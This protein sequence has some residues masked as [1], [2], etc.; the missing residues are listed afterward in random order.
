MDEQRARR[1]AARFGLDPGQ[2]QL[3]PLA[4]HKERAVWRVGSHALKWVAKRKQARKIAAAARYLH[5]RGA[6]VLPPVADPLQTEKGYFLLF[7]WVDG[8]QP[9][10]TEPGMVE[11]ITRLLSEFHRASEG[12]IAAGGTVEQRHYD[13]AR[14]WRTAAERLR[15]VSGE[16]RSRGDAFSRMLLQHEPWLK[17]RLDWALDRLPQ[18]GVAKLVAAAKAN[19][20]LGHGD[21]GRQNVLVTPAGDLVVIDLDLVAASLPVR[22]LSRLVTWVNHDLQTWSSDRF[23]AMIAAYGGLR[24]SERAL[25]ELDQVVPHLALDIAR[26]YYADSARPSLTEELERCLATDR[27]KLHD[28]GI[29][30]PRMHG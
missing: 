22:D 11:R 5:G 29:L 13:W 6:P 24:A 10:Y 12:Y 7:P 18:T 26:E 19:P 28:L 9:L 8:R 21:F 14:S 27:D 1:A 16:A 23:E 17:A 2:L 30:P 25:L 15:Q 20:L 4:R 3:P